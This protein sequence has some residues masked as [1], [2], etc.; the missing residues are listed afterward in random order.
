MPSEEIVGQILGHY[1]IIR[2]VGYGG[3]ATVFLAQDIHLQ[4]EVAIKIFRPQSA[5]SADF[6]RRFTRE[7]QVLA[8]LDHPNIL[9]IYDYG[10]QNGLAYLVMPLIVNGSLKDLLQVHK[11]LPPPQ[12]LLLAGQ[13]LQALQYAHER[14]FIHRDIK[15]G[16]MLFKEDGTL[17]L[18]DFGLV[19]VLSA[20]GGNTSLLESAS[21]VGQSASGTPQYMAPE[22]IKGQASPLSDIYSVGVVL[23]EMLTG[24]RPFTADN[25]MGIWMK[26]LYE[27]P[28]PLRQI[29]PQIP[30]Q[31]EAVVLRALEKDPA[32]RYQHP[33]DF[34]QALVQTTLPTQ[35]TMQEDPSDPTT[36][37]PESTSVAS[38]DTSS[39]TV[40]GQQA[41]TPP[42]VSAPRSSPTIPEFG[43]A[44]AVTSSATQSMPATN[45]SRLT[46]RSLMLVSIMLLVILSLVAGLGVFLL[47]GQH[48]SPP[49]VT[50]IHLPPLPTQCPPAGTA[51]SA[52]TA[53]L[54]LGN[55]TNIVYT[56]NGSNA[57]GP[58]F[59]ALERLDVTTGTKTEILRL[60]HVAIAD[61]Q[62]SADGQWLLFISS[63]ADGLLKLQLLRMDG[64]GLQT[65]YCTHGPAGNS[66]SA[67]D[68]IQWSPNRKL[69]VFSTFNDNPNGGG[70]SFIYMLNTSSG[71]LQRLLQ[72]PRGYTN[73]FPEKWLDNT[74]FYL[75]L[76]L[77]DG[78]PGIIQ[79]ID[80]SRGPNQDLSMLQPVFQS[81]GGVAFDTTLDGSKLF[82]T[83]WS[84]SLA[85]NIGPSS[86]FMASPTGGSQKVIYNS[87]TLA[88]TT[89]RV[90][91]RTT[92]LLVIG[93]FAAQLPL[94]PPTPTDTTQN[95]LWKINTDG[96]GLIRL[97]TSNSQ[98]NQYTQ[99]SWSNVSRDGKMYALAVPGKGTDSLAFGSLNGGP[100]TILA[101]SSAG[102]ASSIVGW[103]TM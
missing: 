9:P 93:N 27:P 92:L 19:K 3:M 24:T 72:I 84:S 52:V 37:L 90:V 17:L 70:T 23:Y 97:T 87:K 4:R 49:P 38:A 82:V 29:N 26:H 88:V 1:R 47:S 21:Q 95:G 48:S 79:L 40:Q 94:G 42:P 7:A 32:K 85:G 99:C 103:T 5:K 44:T 66:L 25:V 69:V 31:L 73:A 12:A 35:V 56:I 80:T 15:P 33:A 63:G 43:T 10:E 16:N 30:P 68:N 74:R 100:P 14:G 83:Q 62:L 67:M 71:Q 86:I 54:A 77:P 60:A 101:Q 34:F 55:H 36:R 51:R 102:T 50:T 22:Q 59:G 91:S 81:N 13:I 96:T 61:P 41:E 46:R 64:E 76:A 18:S 2:P 11:V 6:L 57:T 53:P 39:T 45:H 65:L 58:T 98:L 8:R 28:R 89:V 78:P 75:M 20:D